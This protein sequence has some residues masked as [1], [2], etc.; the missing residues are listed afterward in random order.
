MLFPLGWS[1]ERAIQHQFTKE[2]VF[3]GYPDPGPETMIGTVECRL[4]GTLFESLICLLYRPRLN[5]NTKKTCALSVWLAIV[6]K[7][8]QGT[9]V[10]PSP[11]SPSEGMGEVSSFFSLCLCF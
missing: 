8:T 11:S 6:G 7:I 4:S 5:K 10:A 9:Q 1:G 3:H 2:N